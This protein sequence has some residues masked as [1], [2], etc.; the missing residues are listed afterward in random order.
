MG[1]LERVLGELGGW[2]RRLD[3]QL[4]HGGLDHLPRH[5][6]VK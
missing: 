1:D 3:I 6:V 5:G 4:V 2:E